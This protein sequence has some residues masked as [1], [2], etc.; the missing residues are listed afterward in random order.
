MGFAERSKLLADG[1]GA[2]LALLQPAGIL[3]P[4]LRRPLLP[5][6]GLGGSNLAPWEE[7]TSENIFRSCWQLSMRNPTAQ[8]FSICTN[9]HCSIC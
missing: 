9:A 6:P 5:F 2:S 3:E 8:G 4:C 1:P 7:M